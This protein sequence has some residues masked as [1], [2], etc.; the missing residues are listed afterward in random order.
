MTAHKFA[1]G[2][3]SCA[4][5]A[6]ALSRELSAGTIVETDKDTTTAD[7]IVLVE[8]KAASAGRVKVADLWR[9][10][11]RSHAGEPITARCHGWVTRAEFESDSLDWRPMATLAPGGVVFAWLLQMV[12]L[13]PEGD[14]DLEGDDDADW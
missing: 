2:C 3:P 8:T 1:D 7:R 14:D 10:L 9:T 4:A 13:D 5:I 6:A 11:T 12:E